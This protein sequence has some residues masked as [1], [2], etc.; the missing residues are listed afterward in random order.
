MP[1]AG[2]PVRDEA[3]EL[4]VVHGEDHRR[5]AA[6]L[7]EG[8]TQFRDLGEPGAFTPVLRRNLEAEQPAP[9]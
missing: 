3:R 6:R 8:A 7:P 2:E 1:I 4:D 5:G 9:S